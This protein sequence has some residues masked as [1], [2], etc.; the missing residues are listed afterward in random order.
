MCNIMVLDSVLLVKRLYKYRMIL[1][2]HERDCVKLE[3]GHSHGVCLWFVFESRLL[4]A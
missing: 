1:G 2:G 4:T 3:V